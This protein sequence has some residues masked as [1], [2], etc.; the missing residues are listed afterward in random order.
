[1]DL[2][3]LKDKMPFHWK[4]QTADAKK[5]TMVAYVDARQVM[6]KLDEVVGA[7]N[8]QDTFTVINNN[9]YCSLGIKCGDD[10]IW[11]TDCGTE[12]NVEKEK[13]E[14]SDAFKRAAVKWG[15]GRF[16]YELKFLEI[17]SMEYKNKK[18][19]VSYKPAKGGKIIWD[20]D[21]LNEYC[22]TVFEGGKPVPAKPKPEPKNL[23]DDVVRGIE[24]ATEWKVDRLK[25]QAALF[26]LEPHKMIPTTQKGVQFCVEALSKPEYEAKLKKII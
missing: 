6:D 16:L 7:G 10:W 25:V 17:D 15:V 1:M 2:N 22:K 21:E 19:D 11:K 13:G 23:L 26:N 8:W 9:V 18:G 12:S 14:S 4:V 24:D 5:C 20:K 3:K